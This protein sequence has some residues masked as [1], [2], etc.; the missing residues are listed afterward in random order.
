MEKWSGSDASVLLK[1][2]QS[3]KCCTSKVYLEGNAAL[4]SDNALGMYVP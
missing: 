3:D 4:K 1:I 2:I